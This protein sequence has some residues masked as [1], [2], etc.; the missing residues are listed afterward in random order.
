MLV[1]LKLAGRILVTLRELPAVNK[2]VMSI[3]V[4]LGDVGGNVLYEF[5]HEIWGALAEELDVIV[6]HGPEGLDHA[7][8]FRDEG[9]RLLMFRCRIDVRIGVFENEIEINV[10]IWRG[11][12]SM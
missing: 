9:F 1:N 11:D 4:S 12:T 6:S 2:A 8:D 10:R 3:V 5:S 7:S